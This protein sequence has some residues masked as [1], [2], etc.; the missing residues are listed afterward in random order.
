MPS[1]KSLAASLATFAVVTGMGIAIAQTSG[2][3]SNP[4]PGSAQAP[5]PGTPGAMNQSVPSTPPSTTQN[6]TP[7]AMNQG[8][9][10]ATGSTMSRPADPS[11]APARTSTD[12]MAGERLPRADRN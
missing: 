6:A 5:A 10:P 2:T 7:P 3:D 4:T 12:P 9:T 8:T 11:T 1:S